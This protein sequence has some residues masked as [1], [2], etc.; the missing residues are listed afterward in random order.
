MVGT[1]A[2]AG[3]EAGVDVEA[4]ADS[5]RCF[6]RRLRSTDRAPVV[7][8]PRSRS[9]LQR[10]SIERRVMFICFFCSSQGLLVYI[11]VS[12]LFVF[13]GWKLVCRNLAL[14]SQEIDKNKC[15]WFLNL[16]KLHQ[17]CVL[18]HFGEPLSVIRFLP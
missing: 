6:L 11:I 14:S 18:L 8:K 7:L 13:F 10:S 17:L 15:T 3:V 2:K 5:S 1:G 16:R 4:W 12:V 9:S